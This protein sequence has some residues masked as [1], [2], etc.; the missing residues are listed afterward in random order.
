ML[1]RIAFG[2]SFNASCCFSPSV[3]NLKQMCANIWLCTRCG[4][5]FLEANSEAAL[6]VSLCDQNEASLIKRGE[7]NFL[8]SERVF[9]LEKT[10]LAKKNNLWLT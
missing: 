5:W 1:D 7:I 9:V 2:R 10:Q 8:F 6:T 4:R 3:L